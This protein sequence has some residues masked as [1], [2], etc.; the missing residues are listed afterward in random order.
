MPPRTFSNVGCCWG[1]DFGVVYISCDA[2][3]QSL[4]LL[5]HNLAQTQELRAHRGPIG[6]ATVRVFPIAPPSYP[7][8][9][10]S[11]RES[12]REGL[13]SS[14]KHFKAFIRHCC[15]CC[16]VH[17]LTLSLVQQ[18]RHHCCQLEAG[19]LRGHCSLNLQLQ[20]LNLTY[21]YCLRKTCW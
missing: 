11:K 15:C 19:V 6:C 7:E 14:G 3:Q 12:K 17:Y 8:L 13:Q 10:G 16:W 4:H 20:Y 5:V 1:R 9:L 21:C 18:L 2:H